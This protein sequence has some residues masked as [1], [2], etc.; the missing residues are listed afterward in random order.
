MNPTPN[1]AISEERSSSNGGSHDA[2]SASA[3]APRPVAPVL[4]EEMLARF[5]SRAATY[6]HE[7]RFFEEDFVELRAAKYLLLP[8]PREFGGAGMTLAEVCR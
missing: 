1:S 5:A 8:L 3:P 2:I 7:N 6:D 4:T